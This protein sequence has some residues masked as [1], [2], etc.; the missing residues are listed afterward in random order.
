MLVLPY[1]DIITINNNI[2]TLGN[3]LSNSLLL[4]NSK[5]IKN[6]YSLNY[7]DILNRLGILTNIFK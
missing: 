2:T 3:I 7:R 5:Y 6:T 4:L 1:L